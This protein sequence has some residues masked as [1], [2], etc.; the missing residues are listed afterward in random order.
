MKIRLLF[1][2]TLTAAPFA[3]AQTPA[4]T[5]PPAATTPAATDAPFTVVRN[6]TGAVLTWDI[7]T[8]DV[9][10]IELFRN[11]VADTK[12]RVRVG[13]VAAT[14]TTFTD[15]TADKAT[16]YW[17]WLKVIHN[18]QTHINVGPVKSAPPEIKAP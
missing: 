8:E 12:G 15:P 17:Y 16:T 5:T 3:H 6:A 9:H 18:D 10:V 1:L 14:R 4:T 2:L 11:T 7:A 13:T